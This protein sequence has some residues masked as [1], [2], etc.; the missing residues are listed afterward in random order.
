MVTLP[1]KD[2]ALTLGDSRNQALNR[3]KS[4]DKSLLHKGTWEKFQAV[5]QEYLDLGHAQPVSQQELTTP[6]QDCYYLPMHGVHKESS[7][8]TKLRVVF[9]A[10]AK[11]STNTSL[12]AAGSRTH[13][14]S[15]PGQD[16]DQVQDLP[17]CCFW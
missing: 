6:T 7:S 2:I 15:Y 16:S 3:F 11:T 1:R 9:D 13:T 4:N 10:S 5:I 8:T 12:N 14:A 17:S